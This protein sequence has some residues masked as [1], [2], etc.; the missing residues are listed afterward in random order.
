[1]SQTKIQTYQ[2]SDSG[3]T[4]GS[5][6]S[7]NITVDAS[8]R[9]TA[10]SNG[11]GGTSAPTTEIVYGTGASVSSS[12]FLAYIVASHNLNV[13]IGVTDDAAQVDI[14]SGNNA[15]SFGSS[16][17]LLEA[18]GAAAAS[19]AF[20]YAGDSTGAARAANVEIYGGNNTGTG[21]GGSIKIIP[22]DTVD[23]GGGDLIM[24]TG[25]AA[26][27]NGSAGNMT[28]TGGVG[29]G[30]GTGASVSIIAGNSVDGI[31]GSINLTAGV[32]SGTG[33]S[34]SFRL[35]V[36]NTDRLVVQPDGEW[37]LNGSVGTAGQ[38]LTSAGTGSTPT[39]T[40]VSVSEPANQIVYGTGSGVT[41]DAGFTFDS[42]TDTLTI[43]SASNAL[44]Q[45]GATQ[46]MTID[47]DAGVNLSS[48]TFNAVRVT[49]TGNAQAG[50]PSRTTSAT[51]GFPYIPTTTGTPV[52]TPTAITGMAPMVVDVGA[53]KL[54]I[55]YG[56]AWHFTTLT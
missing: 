36:G 30:T 55:Y 23:D 3:A 29:F 28:F 8:G 49:A 41:S 9:I 17:I 51:D 7:A 47:A 27:G 31:A 18:P 35:N 26:S 24:E 14:R 16:R 4:P 10:A 15:S 5:Y 52:G 20:I 21:P 19:D 1:M 43:T 32:F 2:L 6:T 45:A 13:N 37:N 44:I 38:V 54:W 25:S 56:G 46:S 33:T 53:G 48:N 12:P 50:L 11:S 22:G 39:W 34:G 42:G 40:T